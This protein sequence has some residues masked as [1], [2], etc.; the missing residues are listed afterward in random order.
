MGLRWLGWLAASASLLLSHTAA[1][2]S[3]VTADVDR[4]YPGDKQG[5]DPGWGGALRVGKRW[6]LWVLNLTPELGASYH[7]F[8]GS[9]NAHAVRALAGLRLALGLILQP[10]VFAR[11]GLARFRSPDD[12]GTVSR[13]GLGYD[14]GLGLDFTLIPKIDF[15]AHVSWSAARGRDDAPDLTWLSVGGHVTLVLDD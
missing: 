3:T 13:T 4:T 1:A 7:D 8:G 12:G 14:A 11:A 5:V 2:D 15:G 10:S 9:A 6:D